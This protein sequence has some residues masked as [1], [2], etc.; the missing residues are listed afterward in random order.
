[1]FEFECWNVS[2]WE[3]VKRH[4]KEIERKRHK[5]IETEDGNDFFM[6]SD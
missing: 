4:W 5:D 2:L 6:A 3:T 1:M